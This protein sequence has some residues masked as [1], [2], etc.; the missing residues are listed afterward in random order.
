MI[1]DIKGKNRHR[2]GILYCPKVGAFS[3]M[4]RWL[5]IRQYLAEKGVEYDSIISENFSSIERQARMFADNGYE[6]I[7]LVGGDGALQDALNGIMSSSNSASVTL[8]IIPHGIAN[9]F[10]NYWGMSVGDYRAA[11]DCIIARRVRKVDVGCCHY[12]NENGAVKRYFLNVLNIGLSAHIVELANRRLPF[13]AK[14]AYRVRG[15]CYLL[16]RRQ[17]FAMKFKLNSQVVNKKFMMLCIG[18][19]TGYGMTPSAVPYNG[20]LDVSAI[21]MSRFWGL[22]EGLMMVVRR[23]ILNY[24]LVEPF[25]SAEIVID[26]VGGAPLGIDGRPFKPTFPITVTVEPEMLNLIIPTK[27]NKRL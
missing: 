6:T 14:A 20:W 24:K 8:G 3:P 5:E 11:I 26:D 1:C 17:N 13:F 25:R 22:L 16:F 23:K 19:S 15:L 4:K 18:N 9:D 10:A 27:I 21:R 2:W 12:N 7:V